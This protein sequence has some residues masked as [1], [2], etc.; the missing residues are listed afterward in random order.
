MYEQLTKTITDL[1]AI[2]ADVRKNPRKYTK[3]MI[4]VF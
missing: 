3:G 4:R 1:N 2:L